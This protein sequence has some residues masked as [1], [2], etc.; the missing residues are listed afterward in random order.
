[1]VGLNVNDKI[2]ILL[3]V[4]LNTFSLYSCMFKE[5]NMIFYNGKLKF[6]LI[7]RFFHSQ[8]IRPSCICMYFTIWIF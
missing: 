3:I 6:T 4:K 1:M 2:N 8:E 7:E 5:R